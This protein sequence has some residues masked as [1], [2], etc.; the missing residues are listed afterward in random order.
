MAGMGS[1]SRQTFGQ[2]VRRIRKALGMTQ[3]NLAETSEL[4]RSYIGGVERGERNPTLK[5]ILSLASA[6]RV[7]PAA[8]FANVGESVIQTQAPTMVEALPTPRGLLVRS[9]TT[10]M[11][12]NILS[13]VPHGANLMK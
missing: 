2:N 12:Q 9:S 3:E 7:S 4:D 5:A 13:T 1:S 10:N 6:L 8:L 11:M